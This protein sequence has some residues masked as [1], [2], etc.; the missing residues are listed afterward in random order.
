MK[1]EKG[2]NTILVM[3]HEEI[4]NIPRSKVI[5][6]ARVVP[7]YRPQKEDPYRV[8]ITAS[9]NLIKYEGELTTLTADMLTLKLYGIVSLAQRVQDTQ[10]LALKTSILEHQ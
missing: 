6:Y 8:H 5:T 4:E 9:G 10:D 2:T 7:D 1:D 3:T